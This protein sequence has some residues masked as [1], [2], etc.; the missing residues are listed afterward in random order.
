MHVLKQN[1]SSCLDVKG[2]EQRGTW[3]ES[4]LRLAW[5]VGVPHKWQL[6]LIICRSS[7]FFLIPPVIIGSSN[8]SS[9]WPACLF[10]QEYPMDGLVIHHRQIVSFSSS[11]FSPR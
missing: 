7:P 5:R 8:S 11:L 3:H 2:R 1:K 4:Q 9:V 10:S 6:V